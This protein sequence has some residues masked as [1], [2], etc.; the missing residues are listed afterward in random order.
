MK[1]KKQRKANDNAVIV[2]ERK[3]GGTREETY[4]I[5][6]TV[7]IMRSPKYFYNAQIFD[8]DN[9]LLASTSFRDTQEEAIKDAEN[10][11]QELF[12]KIYIDTQEAK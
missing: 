6:L 5:R 8:A 10:K 3:Y 9:V 12:Y 4:G 11:L 7:R 1:T 2:A